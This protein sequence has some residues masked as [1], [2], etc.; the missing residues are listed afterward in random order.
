MYYKTNTQTN[1]YHVCPCTCDCVV[2]G[3]YT[4]EER[5]QQNKITTKVFEYT[6]DCSK[7]WFNQISAYIIN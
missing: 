5:S 2:A 6:L 4:G 1:L 3:R 7:H